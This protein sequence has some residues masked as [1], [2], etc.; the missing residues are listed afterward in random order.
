MAR[1]KLF[2]FPKKKYKNFELNFTSV[3]LRNNM[4]DYG[5]SGNIQTSYVEKIVFIYFLH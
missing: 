1:G 3:G 5:F 4:F 2:E